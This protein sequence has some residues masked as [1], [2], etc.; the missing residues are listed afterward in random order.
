MVTS[1]GSSGFYPPDVPFDRP[2]TQWRGLPPLAS[3]DPASQHR[4]D[5]VPTAVPLKP[6]RVDTVGCALD[7]NGNL[8]GVSTAHHVVLVHLYSSSAKRLGWL[9]LVGL[10]RVGLDW[11]TCNRTFNR[12][13]VRSIFDVTLGVRP[14]QSHSKTKLELSPSRPTAGP[15]ST[16]W[17]VQDVGLDW[18]PYRSA[19]LPQDLKLIRHR[20]GVWGTARLER[21]WRTSPTR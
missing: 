21:W 17:L 2:S 14:S 8:V 9:G 13:C 18:V 4:I 20:L 6:P 1:A 10:G 16:H 11:E 12:T 5:L 3:F 15:G 19:L 7:R